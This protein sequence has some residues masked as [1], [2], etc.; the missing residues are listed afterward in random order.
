MQQKIVILLSVLLLLITAGCVSTRE[1]EYLAST[2]GRELVVP[3]HFAKEKI[4]LEY[5]VPHIAGKPGAKATPPDTHLSKEEKAAEQEVQQIAHIPTAAPIATTQVTLQENQAYPQLVL[6][7]P[8]A[9]AW[10]S[11]ATGLIRKHLKVVSVSAAKKQFFIA[12]VYDDR[13][14]RQEAPPACIQ[15]E[16]MDATTTKIIILDHEGKQIAPKAAA[17]IL[18]VL[19]LG[20]QSNFRI[21]L[22]KLFR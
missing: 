3:T 11:V 21:R 6:K 20:M 18:H 14:H 8:L 2:H 1:H 19:Q 16:A 10:S 12:R 13:G 5:V 7:Q 9:Q 15:L 17:E 22:P 4:K